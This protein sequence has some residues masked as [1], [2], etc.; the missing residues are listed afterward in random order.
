MKAHSYLIRKES[1]RRW[2]SGEKKSE[3]SR[4]MGIDYHC[5]LNWISCFERLGELG[6]KPHY[7]QCGRKTKLL[8][9]IKEKIIAFRQDH[10][11]W[12]GTYIQLQ[13]KRIFPDAYIPGARQVQRLLKSA[14][15][16]PKRNVQPLVCGDWAK[17]PFD[18]VQTD[19]KE[20]LVTKDGKPCCYLNLVDEYTG[21]ALGAFVF[22]LR[23]HQ[24]STCRT[25]V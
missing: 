17:H 14:D 21:A 4:S 3:I 13:A 18:R 20:R 15:L 24:P 11:E 7:E 19:A 25:G 9:E 2:Q 23:T 1:I 22:P 8:P 10:D 5:L 6:L 16:M 12:G